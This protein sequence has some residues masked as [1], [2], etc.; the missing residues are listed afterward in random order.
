[1]WSGTVAEFLTRV[2]SGELTSLLRRSFL[3]KGKVVSP[4]EEHAWD[5]SLPAVAAALDGQGLDAHYMHILVEVALPQTSARADIV[6]LGA[7]A[8]GGRGVVVLELKHWHSRQ[9]RGS[10][11]QMV[12]LGDGYRKLHPCAQV[13]GYRDYIRAYHAAIV[14]R[15]PPAAVHGCAYL[16]RLAD[17]STLAM[18]VTAEA[19]AANAELLRQCPAFGAGDGPQL[20]AWI[21]DRL[22]APP[23]DAY[24]TEFRRMEKRASRDVARSLKQAVDSGRI[25]WV[26]L[27]AQR[28]IMVQIDERLRTLKAPGSPARQVLIVTGD[29]GS[30]KTVLAMTTLLHAVTQHEL[31]NSYLVATSSAQRTSIEG[32]ICRARGEPLPPTRA[33]QAQPVLK[34][35]ELHIDVPGERKSRKSTPRDEW[36]A[37]CAAWRARRLPFTDGQTPAYDVLVVDEAQGLVDPT[38]PYVDGSQAN[39]WRRPFGPQAWHVMMQA[40]LSIFFMDADQGYRQV[41]S[42]KPQDIEALCAE[43][44]IPCT[45]LALGDEQFRVSGGRAYVDWLNDLLGFNPQGTPLPELSNDERTRLRSI[46]AICTRPDEMRDRLRAL[47]GA[48][49]ADGAQ[50]RL[51]AGYAWDWVSRSE[52]ERTLDSHDGL[53]LPERKPPPGLSFRWAH[54]DGQRDFNLGDGM[55]AAPQ[56]LFGAGEDQPATA[57]Y[58]LT[59]RGQ[60]FDHVGVLWGMDLVWRNGRWIADPNLVFGSDMPQ[61]RK[62]ARSELSAQREDGPGMRELVRAIAGA[63]RILLTR[64]TKTVQVWIEDGET[65]DYVRA[66]WEAFLTSAATAAQAGH[67]G[68]RTA[69]TAPDDAHLFAPGEQQEEQQEQ[70]GHVTRRA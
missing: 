26:L 40:R 57:G 44:G 23:D 11:P 60:E 65:A 47:H 6:L 62:A 4:Y 37:Y 30:G 16:H 18:G 49:G 14:D 34:S 21:R 27:D 53:A 7:D 39:A 8:Q 41:E 52:Y 38:K 50:S 1:M 22:P 5:V 17:V 43:Q 63:Y 66:A 10:L 32:Q 35:S 61:L 56:A 20:A 3:L 24:V 54:S 12:D 59:V 45:T 67:E 48:D 69:A 2:R 58:A 31:L 25:P 42:T 29:P 33:L 28:E 15:T 46:F 55:Y 70:T 9:I 13:Q 64:G 36:A 68:G 51:L 19:A